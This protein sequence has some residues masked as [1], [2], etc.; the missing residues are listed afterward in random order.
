[1]IR[2]NLVIPSGVELRGIHD[3]PH[4]TMGG[5][6]ILHIYP[7]NEQPSVVLMSKSGLRGVSFNYPEQ[8]ILSVKKYPFL[9]QGQGDNI[10]IVN[11][12][13]SNPYKFLDLM[14][15]GCDYHLR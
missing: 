10:Y 8:D 9:I 4:H 1:M 13:C 5:G 12:T 14:S 15:Y 3:V 7:E 11:V 6:S 2:G